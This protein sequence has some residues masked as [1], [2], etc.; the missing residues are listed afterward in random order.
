MILFLDAPSGIAG[1]MLVAALLDL[2]VPRE[3]IDDAL[4]TVPVSGYRIELPRAVRS[5]ISAARF[6]VE[7]ES[8]QPERTYAEIRTIIERATLPDG[9]RALASRAFRILAE[10]EAAVHR[11][12]LD[13]VH[14]HE[15]GAV[16]S[17]VD[18]VAAAVALDFLGAEVVASPLPMGRGFVRARHGVLPLPA[19][20]TVL[21]LRGV[22][23]VPADVDFELVT[24]TGA[25]LVAAAATRFARWPAMRPDRV[26]WGAGARDLPD[27]PNALR[28]V[29]GAPLAIERAT[30]ADGDATF[31]APF[32]VLEANVDDTTGELAAFSVERALA[33]G[34]LDAW[35][36]PIAMK[37]GRPALQISAL[38]RRASL[39][40]L[41]RVLLA[42]TT[43]LGVRWRPV[44]RF[45][46]PRRMVT[47]DTP[48]GAIPVKIADG[49]GIAPNAAPE[50]DACREAALRH[51]VSLR[52]VYAAAL[53][54]LALRPA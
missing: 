6:V 39:E 8:A 2:G 10:A 7:G 37:K 14:F 41:A 38:A 17:I 35:T 30:P 25:C 5:G 32:V 13:E 31:D 23:T 54:A 50:H 24:P 4:A 33:H 18:V 21:A 29:L 43:T 46:R 42:E 16:D 28:A 15:V 53:A 1:D 48:Y 20:A 34:A 40:E 26:G 22:P 11:A 49:D 12:P 3:P 36:T 47:V 52:E 44:A 45:E 9:A 27:R 19:P 51:G